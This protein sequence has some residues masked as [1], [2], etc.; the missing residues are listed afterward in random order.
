M[1]CVG[2]PWLALSANG[3]RE[4]VLNGVPFASLYPRCPRYPC[5][6]WGS[7]SRLQHPILDECRERVAAHAKGTADRPVL[8]AEADELEA[9]LPEILAHARALIAKERSYVECVTE[10]YRSLVE[11]IGCPPGTVLM[12]D[13]P[14]VLSADYAFERAP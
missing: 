6:A 9:R 10:H 4:Y 5:D 8:C 7:G 11:R 13:W 2:T 1:Q 14:A 12:S 3:M